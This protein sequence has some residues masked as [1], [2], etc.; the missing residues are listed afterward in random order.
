MLLSVMRLLRFI[1]Y[2]R[3][4]G[5]RPACI[6]LFTDRFSGV[7]TAL[8]KR[9]ESE[10]MCKSLSSIETVLK[11]SDLEKKLTVLN[12]PSLPSEGPST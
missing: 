6:I 2:P 11:D 3:V 9:R 8:S 4:G 7:V 12:T 10:D 1:L 5:V